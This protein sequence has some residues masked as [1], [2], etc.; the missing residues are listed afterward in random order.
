MMHIKGLAVADTLSTVGG[1]LG[2]FQIWS[3]L[4]KADVNI[5]A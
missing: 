5:L 2:Y 4:N 1:R 3:V